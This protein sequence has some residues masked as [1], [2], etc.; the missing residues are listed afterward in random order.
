[1]HN[2]AWLFDADGGVLA[3]DVSLGSTS[4]GASLAWDRDRFRGMNTGQAPP[5]MFELAVLDV[6]TDGGVAN[7][8]NI[9]SNPPG[10][11]LYPKV[12]MGPGSVGMLV[13]QRFVKPRQR[14][15]ARLIAFGDAGLP[16]PPLDS[17]VPDSGAPS[18]GG[19][20]DAGRGAD[21]GLLG[22]PASL[23]VG[24]GC[25]ASSFTLLPALLF[26]LRLRRLIRPRSG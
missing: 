20:P 17:G 11:A 9:G 19:E 22:Q 18:D 3:D 13:E 16:V 26:A 21:G 10:D 24:C 12:A 23:R 4:V 5:A 8:G 7:Y 2:V 14:A 1:V 25:D 15:F 6:F